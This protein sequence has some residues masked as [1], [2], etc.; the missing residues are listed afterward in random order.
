MANGWTS[1]VY[2][3]KLDQKGEIVEI[4]KDGNELTVQ[5]GA[6]TANV[7]SKDCRFIS[8]GNMTEDFTSAN[9]STSTKNTTGALLR[10]AATIQREIDIRGM[11]VNEAESIVGKF[12]D[13][14]ALTGLKTVL[15][16]HGKGTGALRK[17][18]HDFLKHNKS[19]ASFQFADI[20]EGGTGATL[21]TIK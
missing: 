11:M 13:D 7:K 19:V 12:I 1:T 10:V 4:S 20:D 15:I 6:L 17:G 8:H 14:A 16:I 3:T 21:V 9:T 2:I 18:I 5:V